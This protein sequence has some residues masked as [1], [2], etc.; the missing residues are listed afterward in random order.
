MCNPIVCRVESLRNEASACIV[1]S[2]HQLSW[3][4][5]ER[6]PH[7]WDCIARVRVY[8]AGLLNDRLPT[9]STNVEHYSEIAPG[10]GHGTYKH[11]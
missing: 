5:P 11:Q 3:D 6:A 2:K 8:V 1:F 9:G 7:K 4:E 10:K